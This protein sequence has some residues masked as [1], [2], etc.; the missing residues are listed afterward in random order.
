MYPMSNPPPVILINPPLPEFNAPALISVQEK[1]VTMKQ[2]L[3]IKGIHYK[4]ESVYHMAYK[5]H[6]ST[7]PL[8]FTEVT[9]VSTT[10]ITWVFDLE[11]VESMVSCGV[12]KFRDTTGQLYEAVGPRNMDATT[13]CFIGDLKF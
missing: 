12:L 10:D 5:E 8:R 6:N 13:V 3:H 9:V 7:A 4:P 1:I 11:Q 2:T